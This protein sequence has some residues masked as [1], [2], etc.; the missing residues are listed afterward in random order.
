[1]IPT[2]RRPTKKMEL[3]PP[4]NRTGLNGPDIPLMVGDGLLDILLV[5]DRAATG[6]D[7]FN[8]L[9]AIKQRGSRLQT[10]ALC[11]DYEG[12]T[13]EQLEGKPAAVDDLCWGS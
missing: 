9:L 6:M 11:F 4:I 7:L 13:E 2:D 3:Y 10:E 5:G 12:V 8:N 1:M